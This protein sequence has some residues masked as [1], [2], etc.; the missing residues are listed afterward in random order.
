[1]L[2][3]SFAAHRLVVSHGALSLG[4]SYLSEQEYAKALDDRFAGA[5]GLTIAVV[6]ALTMASAVV[7]PA[8]PKV[9]R[10]V[11]VGGSSLAASA[12]A[13]RFAR[14]LQRILGLI[15]TGAVIAGVVYLV[16][17]LS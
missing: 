3:L 6:V 4:N 5:A 17:R 11:L 9:V 16:W 13:I 15:L 8:W 12:I 10:F 1:M 7:D 2:V 14:V